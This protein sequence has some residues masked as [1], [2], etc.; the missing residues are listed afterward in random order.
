MFSQYL[1]YFCVIINLTF[2]FFS[3][4]ISFLLFRTKKGIVDMVFEFS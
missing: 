2:H 1:G 3:L 4:D